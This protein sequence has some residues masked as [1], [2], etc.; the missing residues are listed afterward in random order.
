MEERKA[1]IRSFVSKGMK[2]DYAAKIA[3]M[4]KS[5]YYYKQSAGKRGRKPSTHSYTHDG[6]RLP[7]EYIVSKIKSVLSQEFMENGYQKMAK[8]L[9]D[10]GYQISKSKTYRLMRENRLLLSRKKKGAR[11]HVSFTQ[12][13]P[14]EPFEK[15]E[16]D[17]KFIYIRGVRKNALLLTIIDT[18]TRITLGWDLQFSIRQASVGKLFSNVIDT[19]LMDYRSPFDENFSVTLRSDNDGRFVAHELQKY[20]KEN[21]IN[22]EFIIPATPQ[23]DAHIESFHSVVEQLVCKK[24]EFED[25]HHARDVFSRFYETYNN[26][27]T[28]S[29]LQ[30]L[31]PIQFLKQWQDGNLGMKLVKKHGRIKQTFFFRGQ[32]PHWLSVPP[33]DFL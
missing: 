12:P 2:V 7:N 19:W 21:F 33:E 6:C 26:R 11:E 20:L 10:M 3:G 22:Q 31:S 1:I 4:S 18:F 29:S 13:L 32:R 9:K 25:I 27:R 14:F 17:I 16:M 30:Y 23:Q 28:I 24:Y 8:E 15:L 5:S